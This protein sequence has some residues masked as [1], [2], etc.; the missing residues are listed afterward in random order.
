MDIFFLSPLKRNML[1]DADLSHFVI[2]RDVCT[3]LKCTT[4]TQRV[5][6]DNFRVFC[7]H[8]AAAIQKGMWKTNLAQHKFFYMF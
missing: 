1:H 5:N 3:K 6:R 2:L 4:Y 8:T 7:D